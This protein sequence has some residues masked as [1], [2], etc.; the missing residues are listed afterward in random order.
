MEEKRISDVVVNLAKDAIDIMHKED[1]DDMS[2][3]LLE[4][5]IQTTLNF[6]K[7]KR[8]EE[9]FDRIEMLEQKVDTLLFCTRSI[10][11]AIL[12][13]YEY[14]Q[15]HEAALDDIN[16]S[17]DMCREKVEEFNKKWPEI[18]SLENVNSLR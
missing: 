16:Y 3:K 4:N 17:M 8:S 14:D 12:Q 18:W 13:A 5:T 1:I 6:L 7:G 2:F 11:S 15:I 10:S 9:K